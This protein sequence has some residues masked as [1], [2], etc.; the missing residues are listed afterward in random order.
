VAD[1]KPFDLLTAALVADDEIVQADAARLLG[2]LGS[3]RAV[4]ALGRYVTECRYYC[5][6]AGSDALG[7]IGD[8]AAIPV[9]K[10]VLA[11]PNV[12]D[13]WFWY[14]RRAVRTSAA[15]ALLALGD[16]SGA[17]WLGELADNNDDVFFCWY[18]PALLRLPDNL[19]VVPRLKARITVESLIRPGGRRTRNSEPGLMAVKTEA[20]G[21]V[22]TPEACRAI[23]DH[24]MT[25]LSRYVRGQA[26]VS[27]LEA[28]AGAENVARVETLLAEDDTDFVR[29]KASLALT[30]AGRPGQA[31]LIA[32]A[33]GSLDDAFDRAAA[34]EA[35]GLVGDAAGAET[36][37]AQLGH[38]DAYVRQ[39]AIEALERVG[40]PGAKEAAERMLG[41][42]SIRVRLQA[43]KRLA[44][45]GGEG[46][47]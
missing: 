30:R 31:A 27:L 38:A 23:I 29:I 8:A 33:A 21:L 46:D 41:D 3:A 6:T 24:Q 44:A 35:L 40:A 16:D 9:L 17:A 25:F 47:V 37:E 15:V 20:L 1:E 36:L 19:P 18:A 7:R 28:D 13:D 5:K 39:C 22:G 45:A 12:D 43:A 26:A 11:E 32:E 10:H 2:E 14:C 42:E 4:P 34:V